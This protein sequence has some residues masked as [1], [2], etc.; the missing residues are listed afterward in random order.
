VAYEPNVQVAAQMMQD[1][2]VTNVVVPGPLFGAAST[3]TMC[4]L[5]EMVWLQAATLNAEGFFQ[6]PF[7]TVDLARMT[8][9]RRAKR[10]IRFLQTYAGP[11]ACMGG[12]KA[13]PIARHRPP[14]RGYVRPLVF[15]RLAARLATHFSD[16]RGY[17]L[18]GRRYMW[19]VDY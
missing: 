5:Q 10:V 16:V 17:A 2:S 9:A 15:H 19:R 11:I 8:P 1:V 13:F 7:A 3:F 4:Y 14:Q 18:E 6:G 12:W